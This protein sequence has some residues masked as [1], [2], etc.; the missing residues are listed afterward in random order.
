[1]RAMSISLGSAM[2]SSGLV[3]AARQWFEGLGVPG[4]ELWATPDAKALVEYLISLKRE[5]L[6][7]EGL[8]R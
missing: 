2:L 1:M 8:G 5:F 6:E 3:D 4:P 7:R